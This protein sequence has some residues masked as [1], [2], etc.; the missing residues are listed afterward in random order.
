M[1]LWPGG[2]MY[3]TRPGNLS[4]EEIYYSY[5][6]KTGEEKYMSIPFQKFQEKCVTFPTV[7]L[8]R[9]Y[10]C[11]TMATMCPT[12]WGLMKNDFL[13]LLYCGWYKWSSPT[14]SSI[15]ISAWRIETIHFVFGIKSKCIIQ[16]RV[17]FCFNLSKSVQNKTRLDGHLRIKW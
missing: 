12:M 14:F 17:L 9:G 13:D 5:D 3:S 11:S 16:T 8:I 10:T 4:T 7:S 6:T 1:L 2:V 15:R